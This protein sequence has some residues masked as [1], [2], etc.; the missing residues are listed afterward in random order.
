MKT[1]AREKGKLQF[2]IKKLETDNK[3]GGD[4][5]PKKEKRGTLN[6]ENESLIKLPD[7]VLMFL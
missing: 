7:Q 3:K 1:L 4:K 6:F 2:D 5:T